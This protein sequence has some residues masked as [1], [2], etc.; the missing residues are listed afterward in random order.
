[1]LGNRRSHAFEGATA[2]PDI[3]LLVTPI[4][5]IR[6][7]FTYVTRLAQDLQVLNIKFLFWVL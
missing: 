4:S 3:P 7:G 2:T 1:M 6:V 5:S